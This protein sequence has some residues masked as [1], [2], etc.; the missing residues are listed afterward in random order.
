MALVNIRPTWDDY[1]KK[2]LISSGF[3][4]KAAIFGLYPIKEWSTSKDFKV[5]T[6]EAELL[7]KS[8]TDPEMIRVDGIILDDV[9]YTCLKVENDTIYGKTGS[10]GCI[11]CLCNKLMIIS[12]YEDGVHPGRC[13]GITMKLADFLRQLGY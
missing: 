6:L 7:S 5:S 11:I 12:V 10:T 4:S 13:F 3:V 9:M 1:V 8:F 2:T